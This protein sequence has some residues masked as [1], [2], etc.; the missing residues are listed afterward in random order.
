VKP[1]GTPAPFAETRHRSPRLTVTR[2]PNARSIAHR[3]RDVYCSTPRQN[4][5]RGLPTVPNPIISSM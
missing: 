1:I 4:D 3:S 5:R 2:Y